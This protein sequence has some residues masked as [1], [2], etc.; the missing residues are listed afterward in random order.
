VA[1]PLLPDHAGPPTPK[2][3]FGLVASPS[4]VVHHLVEGNAAHTLCGMLIGDRWIT[5]RGIFDSDYVRQRAGNL[6]YACAEAAERPPASPVLGDTPATPAVSSNLDVLTYSTHFDEK[7]DSIP[8]P[9]GDTP[10]SSTTAEEVAAHCQEVAAWAGRVLGDTPSRETGMGPTADLAELL[11][12]IARRDPSVVAELF[13]TP[14]FGER[15]ARV[16]AALS[17]DHGNQPQPRSK[18]EAAAWAVLDQARQQIKPRVEQ[19]LQG[20]VVGAD[21]LDLRFRLAAERAPVLGDTPGADADFARVMGAISK[22]VSMPKPDREHTNVPVGD[23]KAFARVITAQ[24]ERI[25]ELE[26]RA[27]LPVPESVPPLGNELLDGLVAH[28]LACRCVGGT[29][30]STCLFP[31]RYIAALKALAAVPESVEPDENTPGCRCAVCQAYFTG[32]KAGVS[33]AL[34]AARALVESDDVPESPTPDS[35]SGSSSLGVQ[36]CPFCGQQPDVDRPDENNSMW[37]ISCAAKC[38][39]GL[40]AAIAE[41]FDETLRR[42]NRRARQMSP[43]ERAEIDA[44]ILAGC[45]PTGLRRSS[46]PESVPEP[47]PSFGL[48]QD[49]MDEAASRRAARPVSDERDVA[50]PE[51]S[52]PIEPDRPLTP[53][54]ARA[55]TWVRSSEVT[56]LREAV[57]EIRWTQGMQT[58]SAASRTDRA[59]M[60]IETIA[61]NLDFVG[62]PP[63]QPSEPAIDPDFWEKVARGRGRD[64]TLIAKERDD[65]RRRLTEQQARP[66][67]EHWICQH[68]YAV[69]DESELGG[70]NDEGVGHLVGDDTPTYC[71]PCVPVNVRELAEEASNASYLAKRLREQEA[72]R[73]AL[74]KALERIVSGPPPIHDTDYADAMNIARDALRPSQEPKP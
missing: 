1:N 33:A 5:A 38:T 39:G 56:A 2:R 62:S 50:A 18:E 25:V 74:R 51:P 29:H 26:A 54:E 9:V 69:L 48:Y 71:G 6:C 53:S 12:T 72:E 70:K 49:A 32:H 10:P 36:G 7:L 45:T 59:L 60:V 55:A 8:V 52:E 17:R 13:D 14:A 11:N 23:L 42:W 57:A 3:Y 73:E 47:R 19:E 43:S 40:P 21:I 35:V 46:V 65:L 30:N 58:P 41:T 31:V 44:A 34:A 37:L 20:E 24:L 28:A 27:S 64:I 61:T 67:V 4:A 66:D 22:I 15:A 63:L 68:C 16:Y